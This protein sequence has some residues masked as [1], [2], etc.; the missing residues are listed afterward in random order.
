MLI[1]RRSLPV[2]LGIVA[3]ALSACTT[4]P[5]Q[6]QPK[7]PVVMPPPVGPIAV[8]KPEPVVPPPAPEPAP[9]MTPSTFG[10]LPGWQQDDL[11]EAW[12]AFMGSCKVLVRKDDWKEPCTV[13]GSVDAADGS[14]IRLFFETFFVP[15]QVRAADGADT[16]LIT[17]YY[18]P[19]LRGARK[20]GGE[21]QTPLYRV[22]DDLLTVE[23]GS[24]YPE[25]KNMRL[26]GRLVGKKV[27]PYNTRAEIERADISG[28]ELL[29]VDDPVEA[30]F[31]EVQG[32]GRVQLADTGETV[33][34]AYAE[35]NGHPYKAIGRWLVEKGELTVP[36]ASAQ[37]I[38]AW[39]AANPAR[40]QE[41]F[42][43]NP[44][45]I[46]FK[47][48]R[49][50]DPSIGPKGALGVP[51]TPARSVAVDPQ[52]LPLG[53]PVWLATTRAG[54]DVPMQRL[55]VGQD[56][57]GAIRG[58]VRADFFYGF[59]RDAAE[60]AGIMKQRGQIWVLLPK[61]AVR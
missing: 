10:A 40:R 49:L 38:K 3:L 61:A 60:S 28:K 11:R 52:F 25:L 30:F 50:P 35:Q 42:N 43:A 59:G 41:L 19:M 5:P 36:Q 4:T 29:W 26:R 6:P 53:A 33:R 31:L 47:E 34:L 18:E 14:A 23:L 22:P 8:P 37:G 32:S 27:I 56:T 2:S 24:V 16:G 51:L 48:E 21:F 1:T 45:Y 46:F 54:S 58:A 9:L 17:G 20:R 12:P 13:A 57:G 44:S 15:N 7:P 39:I 55:M